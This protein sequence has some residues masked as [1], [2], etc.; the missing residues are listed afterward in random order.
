M[1]PTSPAKVTVLFLQIGNQVS[2]QWGIQACAITAQH[3]Y[4]LAKDNRE[5]V[6]T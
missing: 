1:F 6:T 3:H 5:Q 4:R 2:E